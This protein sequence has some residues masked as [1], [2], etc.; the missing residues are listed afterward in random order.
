[1]QQH[2]LK[3]ISCL[4]AVPRSLL[5]TDFP[6]VILFDASQPKASMDSSELF[7]ILWAEDPAHSAHI[8]A[9][10]F[11]QIGA[12]PPVVWGTRKAHVF[13]AR[14]YPIHFAAFSLKRRVSLLCLAQWDHVVIGSSTVSMPLMQVYSYPS[15]FLKTMQDLEVRDSSYYNFAY[16]NSIS[17]VISVLSLIRKTQRRLS[18]NWASVIREC[19]I[20]IV[21]Q[22]KALLLQEKLQTELC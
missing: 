18:G 9:V 16:C 10:C 21:Q 11:T 2:L 8:C 7:R 4:S 1:M 13:S 22:T 3:Y 19:C 17:N 14:M 6:S 12:W 15:N 5:H 20:W